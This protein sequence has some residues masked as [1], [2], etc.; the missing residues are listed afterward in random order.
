[1]LSSPTWTSLMQ[2]SYIRHYRFKQ[3]RLAANTVQN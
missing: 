2:E 3:K 1:V